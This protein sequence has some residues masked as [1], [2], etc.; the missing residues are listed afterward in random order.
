M[1]EPDAPL[2]IQR[3]TQ[4]QRRTQTRSALLEATVGC[5]V[6]FG[7]GATTTLEIE[8]RAGVSRGARI[9]HFATKAALLASATDHLYNQLSD[10]YEEAFGPARALSGT[11]LSDAE[12][13]LSG[14]RLLWNVHQQPGY[15]AVLELNMAARTDGELRARLQEVGIRHRGLAIAAAAKYFPSIESSRAEHLIAMIHSTHV[16]LLM[17]RS[18]AHEPA[19]DEAVLKLL[20][21]LVVSTLPGTEPVSAARR[22]AC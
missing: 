5:L 3:R 19:R 10:H 7:Y 14:M 20:D 9:H 11:P 1:H 21:A 16:G 13:L 2:A 17:Q 12:R 4:E 8:R 22:K 18:V 15:T 6:E